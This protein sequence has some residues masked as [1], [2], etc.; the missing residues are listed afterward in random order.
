VLY[1]RNWGKKLQDIIQNGK[2]SA[3]TEDKYIRVSE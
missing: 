1:L 2:Q 3:D